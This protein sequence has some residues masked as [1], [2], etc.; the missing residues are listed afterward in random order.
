MATDAPAAPRLRFLHLL[1]ETGFSGGEGQLLAILEH[2][3]ARGHHNAIVL[4]PGARF[5]DA[6]QRLG[7]EVHE[8]PL[9]RWWRPDLWPRLRAIVTRAR[10]DV[11]HFACGRS[12]LLGG[13][14]AYGR[15][16]PLKLT[17]RR[18]DYPIRRGLLGGFRYL[19]LVDHVVSICD[20][21]TARL[22]AAGVPRSRITRVYDGID[23]APW[24]P[25]RDQCGAAREALGLPEDALVIACVG[26]LRPRKGQAVLVDAFARLASEHPRA[27]LFLAGGGADRARLMARAAALGLAARVHVPGPVQPIQ[28]V[29]AAA[30]IFCMPSFHEGLCNACLEASFAGLPQVVSDAGGN[31]EIVVDG[32]T[33][34]L[35]P[36]GDAQALA[37]ALAGYLRDPERRA[38]HGAAGRARSL[39]MF[40][41][42]RVVRELEDLF[43]RLREERRD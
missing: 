1:A 13:L 3:Q 17:I 40:T 19:R 11:I 31:G 6:A 35:V 37:G 43:V 22:L 42:E 25:L 26:V 27:R 9:R 20:A 24:L 32:Q 34:A 18:I 5:R 15:T 39:Q 41:K 7:I 21:I 14:A 16:A 29:Y 30:D 8:A 36:K 28:H 2:L 38:R 23:P 4:P 33:G 10:A 12:L